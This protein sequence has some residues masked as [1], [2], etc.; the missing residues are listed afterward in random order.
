M[1]IKDIIKKQTTIIAIAVILVTITVIGISY[2]IFF[3]V[4]TNSK[5]QEITAGTLKLTVADV[6]ALTLKEPMSTADGLK[7]S[8][9]SYTVR[10]TDSNL[11]A[12]YSLYVY[13]GS[14][15]NIPLSSIKISTDGNATSGSTSK[16]L[17]S[18]QET[19]VEGGTTYYRIDTGNL[20]AG[21]SGTTKYIR[22]WIDEELVADEIS[23]GKLNLQL[24]VVSEVQE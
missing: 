12:T 19:I 15:N 7:S 3:D 8:P 18:I 4:K 13:A 14:G 22:I 5:D 23:N 9:V 10:N 11:P 16:T 1:K 6:N 2:A 24:Y 20:N 17:T 21:A